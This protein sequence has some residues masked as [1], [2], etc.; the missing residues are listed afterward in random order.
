M[1]FLSQP[2]PLWLF[3]LPF[4]LLIGGGVAVALSIKPPSHEDHP[5]P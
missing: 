5:H 2:V 3:L 4:A 1:E